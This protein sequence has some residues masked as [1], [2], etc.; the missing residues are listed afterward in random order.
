MAHRI[1]DRVQEYTTSTGT[2]SLTLAGAVTKLV[3]FASQSVATSDTFW[4][5]I[6]HTTAAEW[7]IA[8]CTYT[9]TGAGSITRATPLKSSNANAAVNFSSG[10]KTISLVAPASK[11]PAVDADG[12]YTFQGNIIATGIRE[13]VAVAAIVAGAITFPLAAASNFTVANNANATSISFTGAP[14][15]YGASFSILL[16][17][18]GTLRTWTWPAS[19]TWLNGLPTLSSTN[20][21]RDLITFVT[22]D[23]GTTW[24]G[25]AVAQGF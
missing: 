13:V 3:T 25:M 5:L 23:G 14:A 11:T 12:N 22:Y 21:Q 18:D 10:T 2:G 15:G 24:L 7:E 8:M 20:G 4:G 16:T 6:E 17:A 9:S 1:L 19:V